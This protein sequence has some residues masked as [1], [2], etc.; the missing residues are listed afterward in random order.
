[1]VS[2]TE[3]SLLVRRNEAEGEEEPVAEPTA[4]DEREVKFRMSQVG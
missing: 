1:M 3:V 2:V 4:S